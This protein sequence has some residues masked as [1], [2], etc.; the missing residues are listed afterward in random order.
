MCR[1]HHNMCVIVRWGTTRR[2]PSWSKRWTQRRGCSWFTGPTRAGS[3]SW[4]RTP[5]SRRSSKR[6]HTVFNSFQLTMRRT[7]SVPELTLG[8]CFVRS[9]QKTPSSTGWTSTSP[10]QR[11]APMLTGMYTGDT[12]EQ[13]F[14]VPVCMMV[15]LCA[16]VSCCRRGNC[17]K[18]SVGLQCEVGLRCRAYYVLCGS[19]LSVWNELEEVLTPVSGTNVK[20]QIVRLRTEDG[21]RIVGELN[22]SA[23]SQLICPVAFLSAVA[24]FVVI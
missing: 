14:M 20:V 4:R 10:Q 19:V 13:P 16:C 1:F 9:Y 8:S 18:A 5:T 6:F 3:S 21:Q 2:R 24:Q 17:K 23:A 12:W 15:N 22:A 11:S 7:R